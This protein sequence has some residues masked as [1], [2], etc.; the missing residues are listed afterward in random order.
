MMNRNLISRILELKENGVWTRVCSG[1]VLWDYVCR[2][3]DVNAA[4]PAL[5]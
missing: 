3:Q 4:E 1:F 5:A 2:N